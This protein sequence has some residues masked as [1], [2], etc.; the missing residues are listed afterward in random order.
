[1]RPSPQ[2]SLGKLVEAAGVEPAIGEFGNSLMVRDFWCEFVD[3]AA[4]AA[5]R[6]LLWRP[7]ESS[8][9]DLILGEIMEAAGPDSRRPSL[10]DVPAVSIRHPVDVQWRRRSWVPAAIGARTRFLGL[11]NQ[12]GWRTGFIWSA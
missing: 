8:V 11:G 7:H 2:N 6:G 1:M 5:S 10:E 3:T 12:P 4:V 9:F